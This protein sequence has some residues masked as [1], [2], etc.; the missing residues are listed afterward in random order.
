MHS[1]KVL[2]N[3]FK[4]RYRKGDTKPDPS[5]FGEK[6]K[7]SFYLQDATGLI[8]KYLNNKSHLKIKIWIF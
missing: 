7:F 3:K 1:S 2:L 6:N 4:C 5:I 8:I